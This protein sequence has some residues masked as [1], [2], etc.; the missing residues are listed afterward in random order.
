[1]DSTATSLKSSF[2]AVP[3]IVYII[4]FIFITS[5]SF[6]LYPSTD[7]HGTHRQLGLPPC[8]FLTV[9]GYPCPSCGLTTSFSYLVRGNWFDALRTQPFGL[10]LSI[11]I[12]LAAMTSVVGVAKRIPV[13]H[14]LDSIAFERVQVIML[15][16]FI[17]S[18]LYK[19][20]TM[21]T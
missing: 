9:T 2:S 20:F 12:V 16:L 10:V 21:Q 18:W 17:L 8:G 7:G 6:S 14:I 1:M 15:I 11:V 3:Y 13:T 4:F 5:I 19:I